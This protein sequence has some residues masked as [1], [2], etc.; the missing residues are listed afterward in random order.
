MTQQLIGYYRPFPWSRIGSHRTGQTH[1]ERMLRA[2]CRDQGLKF[3]RF[4]VETDSR[5]DRSL[6]DRI[7]GREAMTAI[8]KEQASGIIIYRM[9]HL[10]TSAKDALASFERWVEQDLNFLCIAFLD[11]IPMVIG[12]PPPPI[13]SIVLIKGLSAFQRR[14]D[15]DKTKQ[16]VINRKLGGKWTGRIPFGFHLVDGVLIEETDR[17]ER[18]QRMKTE[19]RRGATYRQIA[20]SHGVSVGTAHQLVRTDLR[21]LRQLGKR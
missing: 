13:D 7:V 21:K 15:L 8:Q 6:E 3:S 2:Y 1:V 10:F 14:I 20:S 17:I 9:E 11:E 16:R 4:L 5:I 18:I 12:S 19:H